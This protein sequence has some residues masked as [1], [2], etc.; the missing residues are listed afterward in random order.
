MFA[1]VADGTAACCMAPIE[2][3][4]AGSIHRNYDLML[5]SELTIRAETHLRIVHNLIAA[6]PTAA[7]DIRRVYSHPVALAQCGAFLRAHPQMQPV[8]VHDTAGSVRMIVESGEEGAAAIA[9]AH[10]ASVY[11]ASVVSAGVEDHPKN[12]TRFLLLTRRDTADLPLT[13]TPRRWK[14]SIVFRVPNRPG[15]LAR[16][17]TLFAMHDIDLTKIESRPIEGS[18]FDYAFYAD[19]V[20]Q[21]SEP[22]VGRALATLNEMAEMMKILGS[23]P[24]RW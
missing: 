3:S 6:R 16:A 1:A 5:E 22:Q 19:I 15:S 11:G 24:T 2:N 17:L 20:G 8:A 10:A 12:F 9:S 23:Y 21:T 4:L 7:A 18:P 13:E 14:T